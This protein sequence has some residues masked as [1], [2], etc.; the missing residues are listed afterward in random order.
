MNELN[1]RTVRENKNF[2][3][4]IENPQKCRNHKR[5]FNTFCMMC[6][7]G[8]TAKDEA[9]IDVIFCGRNELKLLQFQ[10]PFRITACVTAY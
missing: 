5:D 6:R 1:A 3:R 7:T 8:K 2:I 10:Q 4:T 9:I